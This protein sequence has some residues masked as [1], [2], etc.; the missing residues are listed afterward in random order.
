[1]LVA[2]VEPDPA[3]AAGLA[4]RLARWRRLYQDLRERFAE[5]F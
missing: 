1:V 3:L 4:E 5:A 2:T